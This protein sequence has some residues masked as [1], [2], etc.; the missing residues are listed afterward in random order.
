MEICETKQLRNCNNYWY[1]GYYHPILPS[2]SV[3]KFIRWT[4]YEMRAK[5]INLLHCI[6]TLFAG[7]VDLFI[8]LVSCQLVSC[9][10]FAACKHTL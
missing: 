9:F 7:G 3:Y 10:P 4:A 6:V 1:A 5:N 8:A 2:L